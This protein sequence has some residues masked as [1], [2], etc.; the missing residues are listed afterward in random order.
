MVDVKIKIEKTLIYI[1]ILIPFTVFFWCFF[2]YTIDI[3]VNDDYSAILN[4][5]NKC[6]STESVSD[7]IKLFFSQHN[8]HRIVY[9]RLWTIVSYKLQNQVNFNFL[10][11]IGNL[12][13]IIIFGIFSKKILKLD[14]EKNLIYLLLISVLTFNLSFHENMTFA[15]ATLSNITVFVFSI[16]SIHY[17]TKEILTRKTFVLAI[18]FLILAILTQGGGLFVIPVSIIILIYKKEKK[19]LWIFGLISLIIVF[20]YFYGYQ[21]PFNS[22]SI[23]DTFL[24]FKIRAILFSFAFLGNA[25]NYYLIF[26]NDQSE[27]IGLTTII[28]LLFFI[29]FLYTIKTKY[30]KKNLFAFSIMLLIVLASFA[31]GV[32][33]CQLGLETAGA[34]RYRINGVVFLL[35]FILWFIDEVKINQRKEKIL[36]ISLSIFYFFFISFNQYEFLSFR[37][38]QSLLGAL[39]YKTGDYT[40]LNGFEQDLYNKILIESAENETYFLP[41]LS[42]LETY[43]PYSE[44]LSQIESTI[45]TQNTKSSLEQINKLK[46][47]YLIEGWVFIEDEGTKNQIVKIGL[48]NSGSGNSSYFS[49]TQV[50]KFDLNPYFKKNN[51]LNGGF[52]ARVKDSDVLKGEN[53]ILIQIKINGKTR[54]IKTDKKIIK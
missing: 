9:D 30:Y 28:G 36:C 34:S 7:K 32:T 37:K 1:G 22:P 25:F 8:E 51:L 10:S 6:I 50:P 24:Y 42:S 4:F 14:K 19:Y 12:S 18:L 29:F 17:L 52:L 15:M 23:I 40:K 21:K 31:T 27:S 3:P 46:E 54:T 41:T 35:G 2:Y 5:T 49:T 33:R 11:L 45:N 53:T 39:Y 13:L 38:K 44:K 47:F 20:L 26:T 48:Q 16:I 43:F